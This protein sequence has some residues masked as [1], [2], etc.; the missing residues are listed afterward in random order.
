MRKDLAFIA[1]GE[2]ELF[3]NFG[4]KSQSLTE[5]RNDRYNTFIKCFSKPRVGPPRYTDCS[6]HHTPI[7]SSHGDSSETEATRNE[8]QGDGC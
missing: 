6:L 8:T 2:P 7:W 3:R 5:T 4:Q 1:S